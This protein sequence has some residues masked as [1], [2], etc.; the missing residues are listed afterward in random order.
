M[1]TTFVFYAP[2]SFVFCYIMLSFVETLE[3]RYPAS[4]SIQSLWKWKQLGRFYGI[5]W[6]LCSLPLQ[7]TD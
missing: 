2:F 3:F 7:F 4:V 5:K 1:V 6:K